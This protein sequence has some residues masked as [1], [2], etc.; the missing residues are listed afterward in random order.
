MRAKEGAPNVI[1]IVQDDTGFGQLGCYGS[2][3][4]TPNLDALAA[5]GLRFMNMH[6]TAPGKYNVLPIDARHVAAGRPAAANRRGTQALPVE[7]V[8][9]RQ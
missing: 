7:A 2:P 1:F 5:G 6:T 8:D 9:S 3:I 4:A